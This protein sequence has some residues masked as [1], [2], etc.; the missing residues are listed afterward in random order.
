MKLQSV[1]FEENNNKWY[2]I[3]YLPNN[4]REILIYSPEL[5]TSNGYYNKNVELFWI[6]KW[7][8]YIKPQYW[9]EIPRY[10]EC[11]NSL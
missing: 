1:K 3:E 4:S 10:V 8:Q 6:Y 7:Q 2:S 5:G 9:R 11:Y